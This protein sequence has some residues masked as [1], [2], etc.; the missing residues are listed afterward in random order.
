[1]A[2]TAFIQ[3]LAALL[4]DAEELIEAHSRL[5][6]GRPG[7]QWRLGALNRA[8]VVI[9]VSAWEAVVKESLAA[10]RPSPGPMGVWSSLNASVRSEIG[11]F[12]TP[13]AHQVRSL[14]A[15]LGLDDVTAAWSWTNC[16]PQQA[17]NRLTEILR[18]RQHIAHGV[19]PRPTIHNMTSS[20]LP[21]FFRNLARCTDSAVRA[22]LV[23]VLGVANPWP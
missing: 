3:H 4:A 6:T 2:S 14:F 11:R 13:D 8:V 22:Y 20:R 10:I 7:R 15:S 16:T 12:H 9:A 21:A 18:Q 5:R 23:D 19:N 17:R 1:M